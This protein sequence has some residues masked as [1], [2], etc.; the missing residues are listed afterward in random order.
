MKKL[1]LGLLLLTFFGASEARA[2]PCSV[3]NNL[4]NGT[5]AD[6]SQVMAN[7][8]ALI[9][10]LNVS[11]G[12]G[13]N[14]DITSLGALSP[15]L[16]ALPLS[17]TQGGT[18]IYTGSGLSTGS[19]NAQVVATT[20]PSTFSL[21]PGSHVVFISGF[22]NT[23]ATTLNV[24]GTGAVNIYR[25][26][27]LGIQPL[28][29]GELTPGQQITV[30]Y[31]GTQFQLQGRFDLVG[32]TR[33]Y[34]GAVPT[35]WQGATGQC[36]PQTGVYAALYT[37]LGTAWG[38]CPGGFF[39][40]PQLSGRTSTGSGGAACS[41][42]GISTQCGAATVAIAP[43][44]L[45]SYTLPNTLGISDP[46]HTHGGVPINVN[47]NPTVG[48]T[49]TQPSLVQGTTSTASAT[50]GV[51]ITGGV[52]SGGSGTALGIQNPTTIMT[53]MVKL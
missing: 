53:K 37:L 18:T 6:A 34:V 10:C 49:T 32:D 25:A 22:S 42:A 31:D 11:A 48:S 8:N 15:P 50:T 26:T 24:A 3:P 30:I 51:S 41:G 21:T 40:V 20:V 43:A 1:L 2:V 52:Q 35:G 5:T 16:P 19:A 46:G 39:A 23:V 38:S 12:S 17:P 13:A 9:A 7:F 47:I 27:Q 45:P 29:G 28:V 14:T 36:V 44:N 4:Q 33:D